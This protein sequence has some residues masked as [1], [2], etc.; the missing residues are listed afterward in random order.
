[1]AR[2]HVQDDWTA[3]HHAASG[4]DAIGVRALLE[5]GASRA[6]KNA[7]GKSARQ[8]PFL[9][10][11]PIAGATIPT[12]AAFIRHLCGCPAPIPTLNCV[13]MVVVVVVTVVVTV[14]VMVVVMV[15]VV[16]AAAARWG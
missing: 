6:F 15:V 4:G 13:S 10:R 3:L 16:A 7:D 9:C 5:A 14:V 12:A 11:G 2:V 1:M 8:V